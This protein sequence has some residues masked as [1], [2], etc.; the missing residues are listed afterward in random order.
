MNSR[1]KFLLWVC[2]CKQR[3]SALFFRWFLW[4]YLYSEVKNDVY[5]WWRRMIWTCRTWRKASRFPI[6]IVLMFC[7]GRSTFQCHSA[8]GHCGCHQ[9][10]EKVTN[11][12]WFWSTRGL[13]SDSKE[14]TRIML[15]EMSLVA[16]D[17]WE[18]GS[19]IWTS[20][21]KSICFSRIH[22]GRFSYVF[23]Y[24]SLLVF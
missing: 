7:R 9:Y 15:H 8:L 13:P 12:L 21:M 23:C 1:H 10:S 18:P 2:L 20:D 19:Q 22:L 6:S 11:C 24:L 14:D 16:Y 4:I 3:C 5:Y 17:L